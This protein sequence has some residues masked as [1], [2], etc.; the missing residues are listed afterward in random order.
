LFILFPRLVLR[1]VCESET[2]QGDE[3]KLRSLPIDHYKLT[4]I[5]QGRNTPACRVM[6][7]GE[8]VI[9]WL[10]PFLY[11]I[12]RQGSLTPTA[13]KFNAQA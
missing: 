10:L 13:L 4:I 3:V 8:W 6:V 7:N 12:A 11:F 9:S 2:R 5:G 1:R